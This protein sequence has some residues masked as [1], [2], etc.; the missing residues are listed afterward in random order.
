MS[1]KGIIKII[2]FLISKNLIY[3][4]IILILPQKMIQVF[5]LTINNNGAFCI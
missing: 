3:K 2:K 1:T 5:L 4:I